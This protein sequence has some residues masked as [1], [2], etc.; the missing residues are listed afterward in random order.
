VLEH[1]AG[2]LLVERCVQAH[3]DAARAAGAELKTS[4]TVHSWKVTGDQVV[5]ETDAG[6]FVAG[7]LIVAAGPWVGQLLS[8]LGIRLEVRR[9]SQFWFEPLSQVYARENGCPAFLFE[10]RSGIFYG[11]PQIDGLGVKV[12]EHTGGQLM[13]DPLSLYPDVHPDDERSIRSFC[14]AHV[15]EVSGTLTHHA[16]CMYTMSP[17]EHFIVD[18]HP[19]YP[20][21]AFAAGLSGH[22]F[23]FTSVLGQALCELALEGRTDLPID[24]LSYQRK[25]LRTSAED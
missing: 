19:E 17:D 22:G 25:A 8:G 23:K 15:P 7:R 9:K 14:A 21:V 12:A 11:F 4:V 24:F 13:T 1:R 16:A 5:L 10:T 2:Y 3:L 6:S 18:R 20:Q